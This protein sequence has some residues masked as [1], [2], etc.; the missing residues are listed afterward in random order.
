MKYKSV[1][2]AHVTNIS[3]D[4]WLVSGGFEIQCD[5]YLGGLILTAVNRGRTAPGRHGYVCQACT[6]SPL[7]VGPRFNN[8]GNALM[9]KYS[10]YK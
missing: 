6:P 8:A 1:C 9:L 4:Q 7:T 2:T 3:V 5:W 10:R